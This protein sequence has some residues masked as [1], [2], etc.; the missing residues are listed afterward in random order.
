MRWRKIGIVAKAMIPGPDLQEWLA[1][2]DF[3]MR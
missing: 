3:P 2:F 1:F